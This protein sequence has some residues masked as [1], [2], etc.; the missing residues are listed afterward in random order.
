MHGEGI[1]AF[2]PPET[3]VGGWYRGDTILVRSN[4]MTTGSGFPFLG[5]HTSSIAP[6]ETGAT[7]LP[8]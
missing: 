4:V 1:A 6:V 7:W 2:E 5:W 8:W 3:W